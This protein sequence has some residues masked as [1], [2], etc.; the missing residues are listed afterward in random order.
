MII[1]MIGVPP[2]T[3]SKWHRSWAKHHEQNGMI[4]DIRSA[5]IDWECARFTK[6]YKQKNA[7]E[8]WKAYYSHI[9]E[10][11]EFITENFERR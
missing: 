3:A 1:I 10:I 4:K 9:P 11:E 6:K 5:T 7:M 8:T 2:K